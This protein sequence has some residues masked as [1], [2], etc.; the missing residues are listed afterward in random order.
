MKH[1]KHCHFLSESV[2]LESDAF[3][4]EASGLLVVLIYD[5]KSV[6]DDCNFRPSTP[7]SIKDKER[8]KLDISE[9]LHNSC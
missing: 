3:E 2:G 8:S 5:L 9:I 6:V 4:D 7:L 1:T